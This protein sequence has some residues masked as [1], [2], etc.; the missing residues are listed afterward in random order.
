M[1]KDF[2]VTGANRARVAWKSNQRQ[3]LLIAQ[4]KPDFKLVREPLEPAVR[5]FVANKVANI[6]RVHRLPLMTNRSKSRAS[7][8][9]GWFEL[10]AAKLRDNHRRLLEFSRSRRMAGT[11]ILSSMSASW[12]LAAD[13]N[14]VMLSSYA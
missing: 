3:V 2:N 12:R 14:S 11:S 5:V 4:D 13:W 1:L 7:V 8:S 9:C 10:F 6:E